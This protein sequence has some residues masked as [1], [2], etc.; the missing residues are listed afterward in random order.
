[1]QSGATTT[2]VYVGALAEYVT[3]SSGTSLYKYYSFGGRL[4]AGRGTNLHNFLTDQVGSVQA[5]VSP[6]GGAEAVGLRK[7]FGTTRYGTSAFLQEKGFTGQ[8]KDTLT[9][10]VC[11][12]ARYYDQDAATFVS[13]D[14]V[15]PGGYDPWGLSRYATHSKLP[16]RSLNCYSR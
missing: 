6:S 14:S 13:A 5:Q 9:S 4:V 2:W 10:L 3:T 11:F 8:L 12:N 15:L 1:M 7:P 16:F